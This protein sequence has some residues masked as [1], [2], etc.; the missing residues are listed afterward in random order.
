MVNMI[1]HNTSKYS[2]MKGNKRKILLVAFGAGMFGKDL[3]THEVV[4]TWY[5]LSCFEAKRAGS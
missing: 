1:L 2:W 3:V 4:K 5:F